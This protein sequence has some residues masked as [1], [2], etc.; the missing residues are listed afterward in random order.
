MQV[1]RRFAAVLLI[2]AAILAAATIV[3][4]AE[5]R[6][7]WWSGGKVSLVTAEAWGPQTS[8]QFLDPYSLTHV[9][10]GF[11]LCV[12]LALL[13]G[14]TPIENRF[15]LTL[16]IEAV[17]EI[18]ENSPLVIDRYRTA[19][20][21]LGYTGDTV[22]NSMGDIVA[23]AVGFVIARRIGLRWTLA[24]F[25]TIEVVLLLWIRDNLLLNVLMLL[26]PLEAIKHW[27]L[28]M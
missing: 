12:A 4:R 15:L 7:W 1:C 23:C 10:H 16:G 6:A 3:L 13:A 22:I 26:A 28:G 20:A 2:A 11:L 8:Q 18:V 9:L 14:P 17:W 5:G 19:T 25:V 21:A 24:L 27:Q